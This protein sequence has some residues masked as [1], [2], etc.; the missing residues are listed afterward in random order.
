MNKENDMVKLISDV[1]LEEIS[2]EEEFLV[3]TNV[4]LAV[5][6]GSSRWSEEK[7]EQYASFILALLKNGNTLYVSALNLQELCH[8]FE[9]NEFVQYRCVNHYGREFTKKM[10][11][12]IEEERRRLSKDLQSKY[13]EISDQ[14]VVLSGSI[15][16]SMIKNF[17]EDYENHFYDPIDFMTVR[18][19]A[20]GIVNFITDDADFKKDPRIVVY[21]CS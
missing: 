10:Y 20:N 1:D 11:R 2:S 4:L 19:N 3:D 15:T 7:I 17:I 5:H 21:T 13:A 14:Y 6:F 12:A 8:S 16:N 9:N 18:H